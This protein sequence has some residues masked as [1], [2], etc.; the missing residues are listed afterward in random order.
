MDQGKVSFAG[1]CSEAR[2]N[3]KLS[4]VFNNP[5]NEERRGSLGV[6]RR[7]SDNWTLLRNIRK[8]RP[9]NLCKS[10]EEANSRRSVRKKFEKNN[11][12]NYI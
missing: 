9:Q 11:S 12:R 5:V 8:I 2:E 1:T 10:F 6:Q 3:E 7:A 4:F